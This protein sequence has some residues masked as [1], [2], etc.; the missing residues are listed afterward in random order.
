MSENLE[1]GTIISAIDGPSPSVVDF[2][3]TQGVVHRGQ[4]VELDYSEGTM[5][6]LVSDV[7]K[8]N[9][10]FQ[11]AES[12]KEFEAS[13][14][15]LLEQFPTSEWEYL[16]AKTHPLGV[17]SQSMTKRPTYPPSPGTKVKI[18]SV[19]NLKK[20]LKFDE[21]SGLRLGELEY[22]DLPVK[23]NLTSLLQ[24]HLAILAISGAGK[25]Y[26]VSVLLEELLDRKK[27]DGRIAVIVLDP[28]G[29]YNS[30]AEPVTDKKYSDYSNRTILVKANNIRIGVSKLNVGLLSNII[31]GLSAPQKRGLA[32]IFSKLFDE[33]KSGMGPFDLSDFRSEILSD[34]D[35]KEETKNVLLAFI[36]ELED[37]HLFSKTDSPSV[38]DL[39]APGKLT[40]IDLSEI[41]ELKK[42]QIIV[43]YFSSRLFFERRK[44][45][46]PPFLLVLEE[47]HQFCPEAAS[48]EAAISRS[49][50]RTIA[51]E[52]RKF[53]ASICLVS[54]R[55]VQ[56]D[57][58]TLSQCN[59]QIILRITNPYDLKHIGESCEGLDS[60]SQE[61]LTTLRVGDALVIGEAVNYPVFFRVRKRKSQESRHEISLEKSA[62]E[63]EEKKEKENKETE[64][65]L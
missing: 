18:A 13:G 20:F 23:L 35:I 43:N 2:V 14:S 47:A 41:I 57:T 36:T 46:I 45:S 3:V 62:I 55:P 53:G 37:L 40:I 10:Y 65:F 15:K 42:K 25:S 5:L 63:F 33:M 56:L 19:E 21:K 8:T 4:F 9:R 64:E 28:H 39:V 24:K 31:P 6:C 58:T 29:E 12:V 22:H 54:Q 30:F 27:E 11:R 44:K 48:A 34:S 51:R 1:I 52:G 16:V 61:M 59:S 26:T 60:K 32:K 7:F 49:T 38:H 50:I 17:F